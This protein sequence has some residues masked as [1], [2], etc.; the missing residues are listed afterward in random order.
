[1]TGTQKKLPPYEEGWQSLGPTAVL[2][3][4]AAI[5]ALQNGRC[6]AIPDFDTLEVLKD[7]KEILRILDLTNFH[8][9]AQKW[10]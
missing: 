5:S 2:K 8:K 6:S 10:V 1:M 7:I 9:I 3:A 4:R